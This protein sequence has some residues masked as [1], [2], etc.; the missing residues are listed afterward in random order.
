M[1]LSSQSVGINTRMTRFLYCMDCQKCVSSA[2]RVVSDDDADKSLVVRALIICP[3]CF[4]KNYNY[5]S[6]CNKS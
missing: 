5:K 2:Y 6:D 1:N 4:E 3:A